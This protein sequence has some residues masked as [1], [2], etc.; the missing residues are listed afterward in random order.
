MPRCFC[1]RQA[2]S[3]AAPTGGS[4]CDNLSK[5]SL[6]NVTITSAQSV[7]EGA[8][9][10]PASPGPGQPN[11]A[12]F[13]DLPEFCRVMATLTPSS[14]SDIKIEVWLPASGWNNDFQAIGNGGWNGTMGYGPLAEG[15]KRG[16]A[17]AGTDT[18]TPAAAR[19]S[20]WGIRKSSSISPIARSTK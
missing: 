20:P 2:R 5:F 12:L 1:F 17:T 19:A 11:T 13:K 16:F 18:A 15:V 6:P 7:A 9:T 14:D 4:T 10:P 3:I 8:F